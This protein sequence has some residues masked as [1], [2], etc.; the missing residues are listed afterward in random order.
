MYPVSAAYKAAIQQNVRDM[1]ITGTITLKDDTNIN[2]ADEDIVQGSL[3]FSEQCVAGEDIEVGNVYASEL[4]LSLVSAPENPY[5]LD[6]AR[7]ALN[8]GLNVE[9]DLEAAPIWEYVPLG[10]YYVSDIQRKDAAVTL[11]ALDGMMLFDVGYGSPGASTLRGYIVH[12]CTVAGV[13]LGTSIAELEVLPNATTEFSAP[14]ASKI[15]TC[16]DLIMWACQLMGA[17]ARMNRQGQLEIVPVA[18]RAS[19]KTVN[20]A[21][22]FTSDV[23]DFTVKIT[24]VSMKVG[25]TEYAQGM[26]GMAL[27]LEENPLLI[28][29]SEG[30]INT[31]L[32]NI[33]AQVMYAEYV[34]FSTDFNGDPAIQAGDWV[35]L[36]DTGILGGGDILSLVTHTNWRYRGSHN[37]RGAGKS[38]LMRNVSSQQAKAVSSI[39]AIAT[40]AQQ[41]ALAAN[42][43]TQLINDA[44]GGHVLIRQAPDETNEILIMDHPDPSQAAKIWRW[45]MGGLGYSDNVTGADNPDRTYE[46]AM[47]MDGAINAN[48]IKTGQLDAGVVQIGPESAFAP[49]YDPSKISAAS[50]GVNDDCVGLWHFDGSLNSHK[51]VT[52]D[53]DAF[54][55]AGLFGQALNI[56][57]GKHLKLLLADGMSATE[58]AISLRAYNL[59]AGSNRAVIIDLPDSANTAGLRVSIGSNGKIQLEKIIPG[60]EEPVSFFLAETG[61]ADFETGTLTNVWA[62]DGGLQLDTTTV[63]TWNDFT[64]A[65]WEVLA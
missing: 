14:D 63:R 41:L 35:T 50:M 9:P 51:G 43:S 23:S 5:S 62:K 11:T 38:G 12:A 2:I 40:A 15:I 56:A 61:K 54:F 10:Y 4:G 39:V 44:I 16:R 37:V 6:G 34:P 46:V 17:F 59:S 52:A 3:Y 26:D 55:D 32:G 47:T 22:R 45:N 36:T 57:V 42:Q 8:F 21:E 53:S 30:E 19:A 29:K 25:E 1:K 58:G 28:G 24:K 65:N 31:A 20:K 18:A 33:L 13:T 7:I 48:F 64:G 60:Q 27:A 49:G